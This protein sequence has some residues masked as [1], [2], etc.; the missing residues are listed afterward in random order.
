MG[1]NACREL[2]VTTAVMKI[3]GV[4]NES[5]LRSKEITVKFALDRSNLEYCVLNRALLFEWNDERL[6]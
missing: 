3:S 2:S 5:T 6:K 4:A 1:S